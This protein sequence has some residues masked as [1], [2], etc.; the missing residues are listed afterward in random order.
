MEECRQRREIEGILTVD[1]FLRD[2]AIRLILRLGFSFPTFPFPTS[3][4][5][6]SENALNCTKWTDFL[7]LSVGAMYTFPKVHLVDLFLDVWLTESNFTSAD[8]IIQETEKQLSTAEASIW[9]ASCAAVLWVHQAFLPQ[10]R[11]EFVTSPKNVCER[12]YYL[13]VGFSVVLFLY[14]RHV[15]LSFV[16]A[17]AQVEG[18]FLYSLNTDTSPRNRASGFLRLKTSCS[19]RKRNKNSKEWKNFIREMWRIWDWS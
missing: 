11:K 4:P 19:K 18:C 15:S 7:H 13:V 10:V 2:L 12:G 16:S 3:C 8:E 17:D 1:S 5:W 6:V 9:L 14:E